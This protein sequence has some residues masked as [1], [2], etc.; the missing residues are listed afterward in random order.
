ML[1]L[2]GNPLVAD[3][4]ELSTLNSVLGMHSP[5]GRWATYNTPMDGVRRASAHEIVFQARE[6]SPELNCCSVNSPRGYGLLSEWAVMREGGALVLNVYG[7]STIH[8]ETGAG[9]PV[10]LRQETDYPASGRVLL[11]VDPAQT[12]AFVLK[13]RIPRW[14]GQTHASLNGQDIEG[15]V[16]GHY[17]AI[18]R[19]WQPGDVVTLDLDMSLRAW[20]GERE[21][22]GLSAVYRGPIL[23]AYD[24]RYNLDL[25]AGQ[26][27]AVRPHEARALQ[28]GPRVWMPALDAR[29]L[30]HTL[31]QWNEMLSPWLLFAFEAEDGQTVHLCD[32]ASA[33]QAG[34][35]YRSWLELS[36]GPAPRAFS[37]EN[38]LRGLPLGEER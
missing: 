1:K 20:P 29:R 33:G 30:D 31:V 32:F 17:L 27:P 13:L 6:G 18:E 15:I 28:H 9:V 34:T 3:E 25:V 22:A 12:S 36:H 24:H 11:Y 4:L 2:T 5:T 37:A 14:S 35:P 7:P 19:T 26:P 8:V 21:S 16:P 38:P 10:A 23:L